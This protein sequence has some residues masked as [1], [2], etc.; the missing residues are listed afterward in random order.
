MRILE[1]ALDTMVNKLGMENALIYLWDESTGQFSLQASRGVSKEQIEEIERRRH[2]GM[3]I[4]R[5]VVETGNEVFVPDMA[6][7]KRFDG[8]WENLQDRSYVKLPL[9]SRGSVVGV[10]GVVTPAGN[11]L[12][13]GDVEFLKAIGREIGIAIDNALL[14]A[15]TRQSEEH[16]ITLYNLGTQ[17]S[18]SLSLSEVLDAVAEAARKLIER[19]HRADRPGGK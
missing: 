19:G 4:T 12:T 9:M 2:S 6:Q 8:V 10:L 1:L 14:L 15:D 16:A 17:I 18:A 5:L 11:S 13:T 3:D 7:D